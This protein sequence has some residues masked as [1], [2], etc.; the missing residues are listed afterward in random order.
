MGRVAYEGFTVVLPPGWGEVLEDA[1][2]ADTAELPPV[3]FGAEDGAG[4]FSVMVPLLPADDVPPGE[5]EALEAV[6]RDWGARR[7]IASPLAVSSGPH[8]QGAM[9]SASFRVGDEL[10]VVW[11]VSDGELLV[12]A[13]YVCAWEDR[14][15]EQSARDAAAAS[16]RLE[17]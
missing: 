10:V 13:S 14:E 5:P 1:T 9:A 8:P 4:T 2:F 12:C 16:L 7:G 15:A 6:A 17:P 3:T 11:F